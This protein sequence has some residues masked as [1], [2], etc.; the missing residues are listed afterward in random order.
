MFQKNNPD[1]WPILLNLKEVQTI[2]GIGKNK[3]LIMIASGELPMIKLRGR[4]VISRKGLVAWLQQ[5]DGQTEPEGL[6][7]PDSNK[8]EATCNDRND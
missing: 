2:T 1:T 5:Y 7:V 3:A 8:K 6:D 4:Y